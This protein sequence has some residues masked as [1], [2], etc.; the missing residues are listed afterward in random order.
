MNELNIKKIC[1]GDIRAKDIPTILYKENIV[2]NRT[3]STGKN[4]RTDLTC[5]SG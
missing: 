1:A 2:Y 4:I 3:T 5:R